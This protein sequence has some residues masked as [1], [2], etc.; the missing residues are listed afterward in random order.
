MSNSTSTLPEYI[1]A[2]FTTNSSFEISSFSGT[3]YRTKK[4]SGFFLRVEGS[5]NSLVTNS[6]YP[7]VVPWY[8]NHGSGAPI[9]VELFALIA[10]QVEGVSHDEEVDFLNAIDE[11]RR[12]A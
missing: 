8:N 2:W 1:N 6:C 4:P 5:S 9:P 3:I 11:R 12:H 10:S 7:L